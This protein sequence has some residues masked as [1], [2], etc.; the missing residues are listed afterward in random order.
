MYTMF[1]IVF[2]FYIKI[3]TYIP[4]YVHKYLHKNMLGNQALISLILAAPPL[5][6]KQEEEEFADVFSSLCA[7]SSAD[8]LP[9]K[10]LPGAVDCT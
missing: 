1:V 3:C 8:F 5:F 9:M 6:S 7:L 4:R 2:F 10:G